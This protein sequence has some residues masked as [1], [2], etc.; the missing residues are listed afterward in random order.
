MQRR[1]QMITMVTVAV[2][3][4]VPAAAA[5]PGWTVRLT[6]AWVKPGLDLPKV[7]SDVPVHVSSQGA[8]GA[9]AAIEYRLRPWVGLGVDAL[10]ARPGIVLEAD[11]PEGRRRVSESLSFTPFS[12]GPVFHVTPNRWIDLTLAATLGFAAY[13]DLLFAAD[14]ERL[15]LQGG[16]AFAW[17]LGAGVDIYPGASRWAIHAGV[18]RFGSTLTFTNIENG[19]AGSA[20]FNPLVVTFGVACRF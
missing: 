12:V 6:G 4:A 1:V 9:G 20:A 15:S 13:G 7:D 18:R 3:L 14:G 5:E 17:G 8:L 16:W 19:A 10:H 2:F 11:L